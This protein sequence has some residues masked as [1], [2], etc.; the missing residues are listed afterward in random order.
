VSALQRRGLTCGAGQSEGVK[1]AWTYLAEERERYGG[2]RL[3]QLVVTRLGPGP[4]AACARPMPE[5][6]PGSELSRSSSSPLLH[7]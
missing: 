4:C 6:T 1:Y 3:R 2:E 5:G 7:C